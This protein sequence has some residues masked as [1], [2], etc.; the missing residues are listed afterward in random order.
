MVS[1]TLSSAILIF[2]QSKSC[3]AGKGTRATALSPKTRF[4]K[5][6]QLPLIGKDIPGNW[7]LGQ[8]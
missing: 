3:T 7:G 4:C 6:D 1:L 5:Y 2:L 8:W